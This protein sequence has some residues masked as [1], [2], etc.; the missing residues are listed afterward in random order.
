MT[1]IQTPICLWCKHFQP[2]LGRACAA[3]P[4]RIP[5]EI[6]SEQ[7]DLHLVPHGDEE[8]LVVF[9]LMDEAEQ[10]ARFGKVV[11]LNPVYAAALAERDRDGD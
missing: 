10:I 9:D 5:D 2:E 11:P 3:Y 4:V 1:M 8:A 6:Y 7:T